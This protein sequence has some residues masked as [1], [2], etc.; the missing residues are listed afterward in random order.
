M[1]KNIVVLSGSPRANGN[2]D[3]LCDEFI[4][5]AKDASGTNK[6]RKFRVA[7]MNISPCMGCDACREN[8]NCVFGDDMSIILDAMT[9]ADVILLASPVYFYSIC[10]Q[11]KIVL[12]RVYAKY[13]GLTEKDFY[14]IA[15][16]GEDAKYAVETTFACMRGFVD[17]CD[18]S[19]IMDEL[20]AV[21]LI[22]AGEVKDTEYM[23]MAYDMG[24]GIF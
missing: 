4:K 1:G 17:C 11:L 18:D 15:T 21:G 2:S 19:G 24:R 20:A 7:D 9:Q 16:A 13:E 23:Q 6:I 14:F 22:E 12:D 10:A 8:G 5:G 3:M